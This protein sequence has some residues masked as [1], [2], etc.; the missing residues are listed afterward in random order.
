[1]IPANPCFDPLVS[2]WF[3]HTPPATGSPE[4]GERA[5]VSNHHTTPHEAVYRVLVAQGPQQVPVLFERGLL[6]SRCDVNHAYR[7]DS[8]PV[9]SLDDLAHHGEPPAP[10]VL[11]VDI[12]LVRRAG[13]SA[14]KTFRRRLPATDWLLVFDAPVDEQADRAILGQ[15]RGCIPATI[16]PTQLAKALDAVVAG[17]LWFPRQ[18]LESLYET[19]LHNV[20]PARDADTVSDNGPTLTP[21]E[22]EVLDLVRR[23]L[24]NRQIADRLGVSANTVKKH[25]LHIFEKRGLHGRRQVLA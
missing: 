7:I 11:L 10:R 22:T 23:G 17:R 12:G 19:L 25:L 15:V 5:P 4:A 16:S 24:T 18:V 3:A 2:A 6:P 8:V 21:R 20:E 1:M 14:L 13:E 9:H